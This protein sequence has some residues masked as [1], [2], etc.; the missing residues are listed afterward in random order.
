MLHR[1]LVWVGLLGAGMAQAQVTE[2]TNFDV[3]RYRTPLDRE[4][5][6]DLAWG[7][8]PAEGS[9]ET[10]GFL[11]YVNDP[12]VLYRDERNGLDRIGGLVSDRI[13]LDLGGSIVL[14]EWLEVGLGTRITLF[15]TRPKTL[16]G[17]TPGLEPLALMGLG[18][19]RLIGK[20]ALLRKELHRVDLAFVL[21]ASLPVSRGRS[22]LGEPTATLTPEL[23]VSRTFGE[24][25]LGA[26]LAYFLRGRTEILGTVIDDEIQYRLGAAYR[27]DSLLRT[28]LEVQLA[29]SGATAAQRPFG[30]GPRSPLELLLG[31]SWSVPDQP[32]EVSGGLGFGLGRG[33]GAPDFRLWAGVRYLQGFETTSPDRDD[34]VS[35]RGSRPR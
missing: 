22:Y 3:Q 26:N 1:A 16:P 23:A 28:P 34:V 10:F 32:F 6:L 17:V 24:L 7:R 25:R 27:I 18:D 4:G 21:D 11:H 20:A 33:Y 35:R 19:L 13:D 30:D 29:L 31:G 5:L 12:F 15:Q 9:W 2:P 8:L 14:L